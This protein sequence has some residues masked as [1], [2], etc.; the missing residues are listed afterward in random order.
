MIDLREF[1]GLPVKLGDDFRLIFEEGLRPVEPTVRKLEDMRPVL[2]QQNGTG[3]E[4]LYFMYRDVSFPGDHDIAVQY[5][6]RYDLTV[7]VPGKIGNEYIKT[8]GHYHPTA[9]GTS[10]T[11]PEVYEVIHGTAHYL[12]QKVGEKAGT[13]L[14][15]VLVEAKAGD[16]VIVPPNY[17]HITINAGSEPLVMANWV[18]RYFSSTYDPIRHYRGAAYYE[19]EE[20]G[21]PV[22]VDN[23]AY[24]VVPELRMVP[25]RD[26]PELGLLRGTPI[27]QCFLKDP[28]KFDFLVHPERYHQ[29]FD[30]M[31]TD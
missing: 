23:A 10:L 21:Q 19:I 6:V 2:A 1:S 17:G 27:Y 12:L 26:Y 24:E 25:P 29:S 11:Y 15:I 4:N 20:D 9:N 3:P 16:K 5:R 13:V 28:H 18:E 7:I 30:G 22:F 8:A 14:D 31:L